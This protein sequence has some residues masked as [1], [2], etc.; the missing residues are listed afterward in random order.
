M[1][2]ITKISIYLFAFAVVFAHV[3]TVEAKRRGNR[4]ESW[5][6]NRQSEDSSYE[7]SASLDESASDSDLVRAVN[8]RRREDFVEGGSLTVVKILPDDSSGLEHQ[9]WVVRL[10][11]GELM[12]AVYNLDMCPRVPLKVGDVIAMGGQFIWTNKGGLLHWLH[13]DP[14]GRRPDGYVYVN[15]Q[16]YCKE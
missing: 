6:Q 11:N 12:Q 13:H 8:D 9:K 10:S 7:Q 5:D 3:E 2:L 1:K 15:G 16:Y 4:E 14:R